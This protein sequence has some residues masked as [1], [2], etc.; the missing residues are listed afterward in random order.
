MLLKSRALLTLR[1]IYFANDK[2]W[3]SNENFD[4]LYRNLCFIYFFSGVLF[5]IFVFIPWKWDQ[6]FVF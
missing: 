5:F 2:Y 1:V 4:V 3:K 6:L